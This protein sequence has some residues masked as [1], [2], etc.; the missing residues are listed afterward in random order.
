VEER[1]AM[2]YMIIMVTL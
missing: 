1:R 2:L